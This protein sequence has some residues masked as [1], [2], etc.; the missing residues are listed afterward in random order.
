MEAPSAALEPCPRPKG[1]TFKTSKCP[2][3]A[4]LKIDYEGKHRSLF[5]N[6]L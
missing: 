2:M 3:T 5:S 1:Q 6:S 4:C